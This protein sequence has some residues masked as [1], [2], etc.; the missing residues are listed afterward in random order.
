M[1]IWIKILRGFGYVWIVLAGIF[2][3]IGVSGVWMKSGF[4]GVIKLLSPFNVI[5]WVVTMVTL[6]PGIG[7]L[8]WADKLQA[9][10]EKTQ[11]L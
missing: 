1:N 2:I 3:L 5:N 11:S 7:A 10:I 6:A 9:K 4:L 8:M